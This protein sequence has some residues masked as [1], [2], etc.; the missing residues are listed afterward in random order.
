VARPLLQWCHT[1]PLSTTGRVDPS[2]P[3]I[4]GI[5]T[6]AGIAAGVRWR[7]LR[8]VRTAASG[9]G[10][11]MS[12]A[13]Q[14]HLDNYTYRRVDSV[15][16]QSSPATIP[17][18]RPHIYTELKL[19]TVLHGSL[20]GL[21]AGETNSIRGEQQRRSGS[22]RIN[23]C[24]DCAPCGYTCICKARRRNRE[25]HP[26][27][28][29]RASG[30]RV[31][32]GSSVIATSVDRGRLLSSALMQPCVEL[33]SSTGIRA[34]SRARLAAHVSHGRKRPTRTAL[35]TLGYRAVCW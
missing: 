12:S 5:P 32:W 1:P 33:F 21:S 6:C 29:N 23:A 13:P 30:E 11:G 3:F 25:P 10:W 20:R 28:A 22:L 19:A 9:Q 17:T 7:R 24:G 35:S 26:Q 4:C 34:D 2:R 31:G 18:T 8:I 27:G 14:F 15:S 16:G